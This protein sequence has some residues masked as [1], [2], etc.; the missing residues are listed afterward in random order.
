M[1]SPYLDKLNLR[2][3][4]SIYLRIDL[5]LYLRIDLKLYLRIFKENFK[6]KLLNI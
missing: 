3:N 1:K 6:D 4:L 5:K 2:I